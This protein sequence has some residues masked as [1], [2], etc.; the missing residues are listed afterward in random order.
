MGGVSKRSA[1]K[2]V[3][4]PQQVVLRNHIVQLELIEQL[5]LVPVLW[6]HHLGPPPADLDQQ[7]SAFAV[8]ADPFFDSIGSLSDQK[9]NAA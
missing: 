1:H 4:P 3:H 9:A 6:T 7:E 5:P 2:L 8:F